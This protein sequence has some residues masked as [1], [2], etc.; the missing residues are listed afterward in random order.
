[1]E[2]QRAGCGSTAVGRLATAPERAS[3]RVESAGGEVATAQATTRKRF[4]ELRRFRVER[5]AEID[6]LVGVPN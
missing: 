6:G 1:M 4:G 5:L 3:R 2:T